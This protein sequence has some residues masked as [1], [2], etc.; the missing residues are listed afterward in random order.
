MKKNILKNLSKTTFIFFAVVFLFFGITK[1]ASASCI[2][3]SPTWTCTLDYTSINNLINNNNPSGLKAGDV[4]NVSAGNETWTSVLVITKGIYL[5]GAGI[6][7]T[8]ITSVQAST[9][10]YQPDAT[11]IANNERFELSGFTLNANS[12]GGEDGVV[13]IN[14]SSSTAISKIVIHHNKFTLV[15]GKNVNGRARKA[16]NIIGNIYGV[17]YLNKFV[18]VDYI[19]NFIG[20]GCSSWTDHPF[21]W[22]S[23]NSGKNFYMEDN[24]ISLT[25][26]PDDGDN[27]LWTEAGQGGRYVSRYNTYDLTNYS[28]ANPPYGIDLY[29]FHGDQNT[30]GGGM[31]CE[32]Y[33]NA[34]IN[35]TN[36]GGS[37]STW[38]TDRGGQM[39]M[40]FNKWTGD[41]GGNIRLQEN[42]KCGPQSISN[43]YF[44]SNYFGS[45]L[46]SAGEASG[47]DCC[48][49]TGGCIEQNRGCPDGSYG[50]TDMINGCIKP[51]ANYWNYTALFTGATGMGCGTYAQMQAITSC[52]N[53]TAYWATNQSCSDVTALVGATTAG[54]RTNI[55]E[56]EL[57]KC[58]GGKFVAYYKPYTYPHP[59]RNA[60]QPT[61]TPGDANSDGNINISDVQTCINVILGTDTTHQ[62]CSDMNT[63]STVDITDC[64]AIIN[65]ILNP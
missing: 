47:D 46:K 19:G 40:F 64:Q 38:M 62:A 52:T 58:V 54:M 3:A 29:D 51:N 56:G 4:V 33:G 41:M 59:L 16:L 55:I 44:W 1:T 12:L 37:S 65:K 32:V 18:D 49:K 48:L 14:S 20:N 11:A 36:S 24:V 9:I 13:T 45:T 57:Y 61:C 10:K 2:G 26:Q 50:C 6:D 63:S 30:G 15:S 31:V 60:F 27:V 28:R 53:G 25:K 17:A 43:S 34:V 42:Y 35:V 8:V 21:V 23:I 39:M 5:K 7:S 22:S